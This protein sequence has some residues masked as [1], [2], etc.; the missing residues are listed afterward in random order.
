MGMKVN[1]RAVAIFGLLVILLYSGARTLTTAGGVGGGNVHLETD[2][3]KLYRES[4]LLDLEEIFTHMADSAYEGVGLRDPLL[5]SKPSVQPKQKS[6]RQVKQ[7][8]PKPSAKQKPR[9]TGLVLDGE[10]TAI[11]EIGQKSYVVKE[12]DVIEGSKVVLIDERGVHLWV[13]GEVVTLR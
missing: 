11:V 13:N 3:G 12:G 10:P 9:L 6:Q 2:E 5:P 8:S 4:V 1:K 7:L